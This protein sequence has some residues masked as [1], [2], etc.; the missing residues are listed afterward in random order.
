MKSWNFW[1][2]VNGTLYGIRGRHPRG[3]RTVSAYGGKTT[4]RP[5]TERLDEHLW[6]RGRYECVPKPWADTVPGWRPN[7]T[8]QE[9]IDAGGAFVIWQGR[10]V[11]L[12]LSWGEIVFA[13]WLRRPLY[14]VQWNQANTRRIK[15]SVAREQ[16]AKRDLAR[17]TTTAPVRSSAGV[18]KVAKR[19]MSVPVVSVAALSTLLLLIPGVPTAVEEGAQWSWSNPLELLILVVATVLALRSPRRALRHKRR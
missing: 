12:L 7:G 16:R 18:L 19:W 4:R 10:T 1:T 8:A 13:I 9:V 6:G 17:G 5:W 3:W 2:V 14:N 11:P 15:P